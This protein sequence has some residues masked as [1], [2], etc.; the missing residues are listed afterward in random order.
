[1][2]DL[3]KK[4]LFLVSK[5]GEIRVDKGGDLV[6]FTKNKVMK[7]L[8]LSIILLT[9]LGACVNSEKKPEYYPSHAYNAANYS[10]ENVDTSRLVYVPIYSDI[11]HKDGSKRILLTATLSIR[12]TDLHDTLYL[13]GIDYYNSKGDHIK[14]YLE[15]PLQ[16]KPLE[17]L[18]FI[19]E[20]KEKLGGAGANF[21]VHWAGNHQ[22]NHPI[23]QAVMIGTSGQQG[24]SFTTEG[25]D[26]HK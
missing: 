3:K 25:V 26:I 24:L 8:L 18:E 14:N 20:E 21:L 9:G 2:I 5:W 17:S 19:V 4:I 15:T 6:T 7:N 11:Y 10:K 13:F 12:N 22:L 16:V 23:I 1:M